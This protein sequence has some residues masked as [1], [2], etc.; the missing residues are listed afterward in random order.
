MSTAMWNGRE[1][2]LKEIA[3]LKQNW[4]SPQVISLKKKL[5]DNNA[6]LENTIADINILNY[7]SKGIN[8]YDKCDE[9]K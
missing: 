7:P 8:I 2:D 5:I 3:S 9:S 6:E 4:N 1:T